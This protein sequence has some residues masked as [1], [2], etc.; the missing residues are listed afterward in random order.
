M[1][2]SGCGKTTIGQAL[3]TRLDWEFLEGDALHPPANVAKMAA[4][5]P[6][7]DADREPWLRTIATGI[8]AWRARGTHG[9]VAC[10]AL[11]HAYR[12]ILIGAR[13][14]VRLAYLQGSRDVIT[15]RLAARQGHFMPAALLDSQFRTLEEP[16]PAERAI[17][18][19]VD[20]APDTIVA[21]IMEQLK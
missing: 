18:I 19:P 13:P 21:R 14:D 2:V 12:D 10:S 8:D 16:A 17:R 3:A 5:T 15:A 6:L 1:G 11:K 7:D 4:G 20:A 9:V